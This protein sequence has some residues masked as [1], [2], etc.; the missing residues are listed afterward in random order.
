MFEERLNDITVGVGSTLEDARRI[1]RHLRCDS[2]EEQWQE[3]VGLFANRINNRFIFAIDQ[4]LKSKNLEAVAMPIMALNCLVIETMYQF[5][6]GEDET[7]CNNLKAFKSFFRNSYYLKECESAS[8][9]FY[10]G[11]R[12]GLLHQGQVKNSVAV[13]VGYIDA[14]LYREQPVG[15]ITYLMFNAVGISNALKKEI[16]EYTKTLKNESAPYIMRLRFI[17]KFRYILGIKQLGDNFK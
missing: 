2:H 15:R 7:R 11:V 5:K 9:K 10:K 12:C 14:P 17:K 8:E 16:N 6:K 3:A 13:E 4:L 1:I